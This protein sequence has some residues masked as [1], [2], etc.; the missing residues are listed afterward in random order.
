[1]LLIIQ[2]SILCLV[3]G[4]TKVLNQLLLEFHQRESA[5][6]KGVVKHHNLVEAAKQ[7]AKEA[8]AAR[9]AAGT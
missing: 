8:A 3:E 5:Y 7:A 6:E 2:R 9:A 4:P 1:M